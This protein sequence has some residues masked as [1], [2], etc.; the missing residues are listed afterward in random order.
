MPDGRRVLTCSQNGEFT[1]WNA[2]S[3]NFETILQ[4]HNNPVRTATMSHSANWLISAD[5]SGQI[6]YWQMNFNNL[7]QTQAH[8]EPIRGV[9]FSPTD[10]KFAT[11]ADD[12]TIKIFD[13][14]RAKAET[15]LNGHG[16]DVRCVQW[17]DTKSVVAS[18]GYSR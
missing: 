15:T 7:K 1:L 10:L 2:A 11:C 16:G 4:A 13:F 5:D 12:A 3:F 17:H 9:S 6:K 8:G 14:A 18:G